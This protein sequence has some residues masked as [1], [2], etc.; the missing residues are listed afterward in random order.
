MTKH[1][2]LPS[3]HLPSRRNPS[4]S[5][6][7]GMV[8]LQRSSQLDPSSPTT[9]VRADQP[10]AL[11]VADG[12]C[13]QIRDLLART[14]LPVLWLQ[15]TDHPFDILSQE[16]NW[17]RQLGNPVA[18]LHWISHGSAGQLHVGNHTI[19]SQSLID[20]HQQLAQWGL[21]KLM[22]W[23]CSTGAES[24]FISLLEEFSGATVWASRLPL[25]QLGHGFTHWKLTSRDDAPSPQLPINAQ[26]LLSWPHQL[27]AF[28]RSGGGTLQD[29]GYAITSLS[30]NSSIVTGYFNGTA[31][32][33]STTLTSAG[34]KD[35]F[36]AKLD[37]NGDYVWAKQGGGSSDD[38]TYGITSLSDNSSI[39]TGRFSGSATFG[40]TTLTSAGNDDVFIAKLDSNGNYLWAKRGGSNSDDKGYAITSLSDNSSIVTG[41]FQGTATFGSTTL[42][43]A[44]NNDVFIAK[45]DSNGNYLWAKRG[46]SSSDDRGYGI[47]S[48]SDNSSIVTGFF[49]GT[50]TFGSTTLTSAGSYDVFIAKLDSNGN[51]LWA[52]RGGS[53]SD[54]RGIAIT[55]LSDNSSIVTGY[56][57]GT[58]TFGSTTL[59]SAGSKDVFIAKIDGEGNYLWAKQGGSSSADRGVAITSLSDNSSIVTGDFYGTATF[60]STTLTSAGDK[61]VFIAKLDSNGDYLWAKNAGGTGREI[62]RGISVLSDNSTIVTGDFLYSATFGSNTLTSAGSYDVFIAKLD[63]NGDWWIDPAMTSASYNASTGVLS[64]TGTNFKVNAGADNDIDISKLTLTGE[65]SSTYTLTSD[66]VERTSATAFSV[67]LNAADQLQLAGLLNKNGTSSG[68][69]TTYNI[70][71]AL[72]WN[73]GSSSSPA[74]STGNAITVSNVAAPSLSSASYDD[75]SGV[76]A[77]TGSN[78]PAYSGSSNDIDVSKLTITGGSGST[79]TLTTGDVELTSATAASITLNSTDQSNLD[80]LLNKNGTASTQGTTYNIAAADDWA[81]GADSSVNIE[82][83]TGNAVTV[84]NIP[85]R[86]P[87]GSV[88]I[89]GTPTQ[90]QTLTAA[91][92]LADADGLGTITNQWKRA[93]SSI[94]GATSTSYELVQADVGSAI[95]VTA[96]YT[97]GAGTAESVTSTA[98]SA[99]A[100]VNDA[101]TGS[102]TISGTPTQGQTLTASHTLADADGLGT[103]AYGW[104]RS[105]TAINIPDP[106]STTYTLVQADVGS[107]ISV[108]AS[109]T[110]QQ[111]TAESV[112]SSATSAVK[113]LV[114]PTPTPT[115]TPASD[116]SSSLNSN[117]NTAQTLENLL[118]NGRRYWTHKVDSL[119]NQS[120]FNFALLNDN[121]YLEVTGGKNNYANGNKGDDRFVL[122]AGQKGQYF[123]GKGADTFEVFGGIDSYINGD[124]G[125]DQIIL[126]GGLGRYL[127]GDDGDRIEVLAADSGSWVNG[128]RGNDFIT[129]AAAGVTYRGGKDDDVLAVSQG[130]VWGDLGIDTFRGVSGDGY[131]LIQDYTVGEDKIDLAMIQGGSWTNVDNGLMFTD[132]SGDQIM[133]LLGIKDSEQVTLI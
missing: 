46:G 14:A 102:V 6:S 104:R 91:N 52:K 10:T 77:L 62:G 107:A 120:N 49:N 74:D 67:T 59:T 72:N 112:S 100:N 87:T 20:R 75:S 84:S 33:G 30:D 118:I 73:P 51:Y 61:D 70:A 90:G 101:P 92:T 50:A 124:K 7:S 95:S 103:I 69:S 38:T 98:T 119:I 97:D 131:A 122:R 81:P 89:S 8:S 128:N 11:I 4:A 22:L 114:T 27:A 47:T 13:P 99:V 85:N 96:S 39:V 37:S 41:E 130:D 40:S 29:Q 18:N 17:R 15:A 117:S 56:F 36:I 43:S 44:G 31:T 54:D 86:T 94:S 109:Y 45:L 21:Q 111:G 115:P 83:L 35:V 53:S 79:Y 76:L 116:V 66:D 2:R 26:Q 82:D 127:G 60:G 32:F 110:D 80:S 3:S 16:L 28:P 133:L 58:A 121:D 1:S 55:S 64:V 19:S 48:L 93:G 88:T 12:S 108:T 126:R 106:S 123:G 132:L 24:S 63:S 113:A 34:S 65:G 23:S 42:T 57:N 129:G 9:A 25:G 68:G 5:I 125:A 78:L 105:G 71:A